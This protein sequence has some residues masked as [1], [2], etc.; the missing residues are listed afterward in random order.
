MYV[1]VLLR[2]QCGSCLCHTK[3]KFR[4]ISKEQNVFRVARYDGW[5]MS[6]IPTHGGSGVGRWFLEYRA[7]QG[8]VVRPHLKKK[9]KMEKGNLQMRILGSILMDVHLFLSVS[10]FQTVLCSCPMSRLDLI[11][12]FTSVYIFCL[13]FSYSF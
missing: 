6:L 4:K 13:Y 2:A 9:K 3:R 8:Y 12:F 1:R 10:A 5:F 11:A 7:S